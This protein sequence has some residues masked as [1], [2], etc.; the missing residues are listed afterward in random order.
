MRFSRTKARHPEGQR[1]D[2][3]G[4]VRATCRSTS[5][6]IPAYPGCCLG[7]TG[8]TVNLIVEARNP[9]DEAIAMVICVRPK[10]SRPSHSSFNEG[11]EYI[12]V[13]DSTGTVAADVVVRETGS[14]VA[15]A[16]PPSA[17]RHRLGRRCGR[18]LPSSSHGL[19]VAD[20]LVRVG[21]VET[22]K[23]TPLHRPPVCC[24]VQSAH[25]RRA[26]V[27]VLLGIAAH[28]GSRL[29]SG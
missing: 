10:L 18:S 15:S 16:M 28:L 4:Y 17:G 25:Q 24:V 14:A 19:R 3:R 11:Y 13:T 20:G 22:F 12:R 23:G 21:Q 6:T 29:P 7:S 9:R 5:S 27:S 2:Q 26:E 8:D 1:V